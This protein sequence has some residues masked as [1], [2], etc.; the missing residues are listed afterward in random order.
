MSVFKKFQKQ[1]AQAAA[2]KQLLEL[3]KKQLGK[4][5]LTPEEAELA[6]KSIKSGAQ[7]M[8][9]VGKLLAKQTAEEDIVKEVSEKFDLPEEMI[10]DMIKN[11]NSFTQGLK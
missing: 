6:L 8:Q 5:E 1:K 9:M 3:A 11:P 4:E 7:A 10:W 2:D